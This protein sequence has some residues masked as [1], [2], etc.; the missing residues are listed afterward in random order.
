MSFVFILAHYQNKNQVVSAFSAH[1]Y[2]IYV[3]LNAL[4]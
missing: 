2:L 3:L 4:L 1:I